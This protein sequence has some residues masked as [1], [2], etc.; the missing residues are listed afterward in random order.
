MIWFWV[1]QAQTQFL[2]RNLE[3]HNADDGSAQ[4]STSSFSSARQLM[5]SYNSFDGDLKHTIRFQV[6]VWSI[7]APDV[8]THRVSMKFRV[9]LFWN[10]PPPLRRLDGVE[11][12]RK[13]IQ[14][15]MW[16][17][18][19]RSTACKKKMSDSPA[20]LLDVPPISILNADSFDVI[21]APTV[22]LLKEDSRL[23][24]WSCMYKAQL[25]QNEI[26][27]ND[28]PHDEHGKFLCVNSEFP[29]FVTLILI[30]PILITFPFINSHLY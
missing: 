4:M 9:T 11:Q 15:F 13:R 18:S 20:E 10:D 12:K 14:Q 30:F 5:P 19:G 6:I 26:S 25:H 1:Y 22:E 17:M 7:S 23:Y 24:R 29:T 28:F 3:A 2:D 21:G 27:C 16:V 8:K